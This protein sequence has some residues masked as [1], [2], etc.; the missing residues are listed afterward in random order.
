MG[1]AELSD[2]PHPPTISFC[3]RASDHLLSTTLPSTLIS[4]GLV[5]HLWE[6][7]FTTTTHRRLTSPYTAC[8]FDWAHL[9]I[10][11][12]CIALPTRV[13]ELSSRFDTAIT[14]TYFPRRVTSYP[15]ATT[16]LS[17][18]VATLERPAVVLPFRPPLILP[19]SQTS[20]GYGRF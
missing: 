4:H 9:R 13:C 1:S 18:A 2:R 14:Y 17:R 8:S 20:I 7:C 10:P 3:V 15:T 11:S 6:L 12:R 5:P 19:S 16:T